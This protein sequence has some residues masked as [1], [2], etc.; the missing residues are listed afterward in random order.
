MVG[1]ICGSLNVYRLVLKVPPLVKRYLLSSFRDVPPARGDARRGAPAAGSSPSSGIDTIL[2]PESVFFFL[3]LLSCP[4]DFAL[5][6]LAV[7]LAICFSSTR[8]SLAPLGF[9]FEAS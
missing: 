4:F 2:I 6:E 7:P 5:P 1:S 9:W 8:F 3:F